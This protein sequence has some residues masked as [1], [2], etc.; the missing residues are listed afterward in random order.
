M[1]LN[2]TKCKQMTL[3][4]K[5]DPLKYSYKINSAPL[6][7]VEQFKY[8]G[9]TISSNLSWSPH[10]KNMVSVA[11]KRLWLIR[12]RLK[13]ATTKTKLVAYTSLVRPLLEYADVIWDPHTKT[14]VKSIER[15]QR[16][17]LRFIHH[18]Y[19]RQVSISDL[20]SRS[21]LP[22][23][24]SGRKMHRLK[25]LFAIINNHTKLEF[26][27]Y[28]QYNRTRQTRHKHDK[29][30]IMPQCRTNTY[31]LSFFPR[32][33]ADWNKLPYDVATLSSPDAFF[34]AISSSQ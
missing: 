3:T 32:T 23:L 15:V 8:L 28:M 2:V 33:I 25:M 26:H 21:G 9:V 20:L 10:I 16:K 22:T 13:H 17:A 11:S 12:H 4:R 1:T 18:A 29:T 31:K 14:N 27:T 19:G 6:E 30:I 34:S 7:P 24:E 5:K